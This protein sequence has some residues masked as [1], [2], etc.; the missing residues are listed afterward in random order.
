MNNFSFSFKSDK[1]FSETTNGLINIIEN[2]KFKVL[3]IHDVQATFASKNIQHESY[4]IIEF[5]RA[6]AAKIVLDADPEIGLLLPCRAI[7]Y[8]SANEVSV[9]F[10][11][12]VIMKNFFPDVSI[13]D[14]PEQVAV[15]IQEIIKQF[16]A[17]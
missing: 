1:D 11:N 2:N 8:E 15:D 12:P 9:S 7:V 14:L 6:P 17:S 4:K 3:H 10:M 5:C 16:Q 13:S